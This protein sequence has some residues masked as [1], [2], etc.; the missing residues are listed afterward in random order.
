[1]MSLCLRQDHMWETYGS[2]RTMASFET[3]DSFQRSGRNCFQLWP[4]VN[5][6]HGVDIGV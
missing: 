1:M 6:F 3:L 2:M 4:S 5:D